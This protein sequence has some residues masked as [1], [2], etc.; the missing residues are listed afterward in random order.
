MKQGL[1]L[2]NLGTPEAPDYRS[3][4]RYLSTFL[5][6]PF[7]LDLPFFAR[8]IL[9]YGLILPFRVKKTAHA[10]QQIWTQDGSPLRYLSISLEMKLQAVLGNQYQVALGMRYGEPSILNGLRRLQGC[11]TLTILPL[12]PQYAQSTTQSSIEYVRAQLKKQTDPPILR[13]IPDFYQHSSFITPLAAFMK[14]HLTTHDHFLFS[15]HGVPE[16]HLFK[17]GC[18][19]ICEHACPAPMNINPACYRA[20]CFATSRALAKILGLNGTQYT[21]AFQSR[22]GKTPWIGP[23]L[24]DALHMLR[25][26]NIKNL[27]VATPSFVTDCLE[28]LEEIG[29]RARSLWQKLGGGQFTLIPCLNDDQTWVEGIVELLES[30]S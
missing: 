26:R 16:R 23:D 7:V 25:Q 13:I 30:T 29:L 11:R 2:I 15:Y 5:S 3:V 6:D 4:R 10:Y 28:T 22:F 27:A 18:K 9:L 19:S 14:P 20:Q 17:T 8:Y 12:Y 21:S 24:I 1:L